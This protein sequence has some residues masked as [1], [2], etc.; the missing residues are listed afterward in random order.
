MH[1]KY[2]P[3]LIAWSSSGFV[4]LRK[5]LRSIIHDPSDELNKKQ[6]GE[7]CVNTGK[8]HIDWCNQ[9]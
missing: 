4:S 5:N 8:T 6:T 7:T 3:L 2:A 9:C 1:N